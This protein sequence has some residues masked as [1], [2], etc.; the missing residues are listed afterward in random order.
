MIFRLAVRHLICGLSV[1]TI[2]VSLLL[3]ATLLLAGPQTAQAEI[4]TVCP[5][6]AICDY[7]SPEVAVNDPVVVAGDTIDI[8]ASTYVLGTT[9]QVDNSITILGHGSVFDANGIRAI[10]VINAATNLSL[11]NVTIQ[12]GQADAGFGGGALRVSGGATVTVIGGIFEDNQ[13]EFGGAVHNIASTVTIRESVFS[14]NR[15]TAG[16]GG[17]VLTDSGGSTTLIRTEIDGNTA[18]VAGGGLAVGD[19]NSQLNFV[20]STVSNNA[21]LTSVQ[22]VSNL[23]ISGT[24]ISCGESPLGQTFLA[25][26]SA[27]SAFEF[28]IRLNGP[29]GDANVIPSD[30]NIPGGVWLGGSTQTLVFNLDQAVALIPNDTYAIESFIAGAYSIFISPGNDY[31][32]GDRY[33]CDGVFST[34]SDFFFR[35]FGGSPGEGGGIYASTAGIA[36]LFNSTVS[37]NLGDGAVAASGGSVTTLF[38]TIS[39]NSGNGLTAQPNAPGGLVFFTASI[40]AENG[41]NDCAGSNF[42]SSGFNLIGDDNNCVFTPFTGDLIGTGVAPIDP[43]LGPLQDNGGFTATHAIDPNSPALDGAGTDLNLPCTDATDDQRGVVRPGGPACD[44]GAFELVPAA[45]AGPLQT[46]I[47]AAAP[48]AIIIVPDGIYTEQITIGDGKTLR[49]SGPDNVVINA[50]GLGSSAII[51]TGDFTLEGIR[52]TGGSSVDN[53]GNDAVLDGGA[54]Y[55]LN[56]TLAGTNVTF[57]NNSAGGNGGAILNALGVVD[58]QGVVIEGGSATSGGAIHNGSG[59]QLLIGT[60]VACA[61]M[62][63]DVNAPILNMISGNSANTLGG[64]ITGGTI[65]IANTRL[66][67]NSAG[68]GGATDIGAGG[69]LDINCSILDANHALSGSG[70]AVNNSSTFIDE[71]LFESNTAATSGGAF[72]GNSATISNSLFRLNQAGENGGAIATVGPLTSTRN[73]YD[74]NHA[75]Y[76]GAI[77]INGNTFNS[78]NSID[79]LF[80]SNTATHDGGAI[81]EFASNLNVTRGAFQSNTAGDSNGGFAG[82]GGAIYSGRSAVITES[83]FSA[84]RP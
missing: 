49:G 45:A 63:V 62:P 27:L 56:G 16:E 20:A 51:A 25:D 44:I 69:S 64:A 24:T 74:A 81:Y 50:N 78:A 12:N 9:L 77:G 19:N 58:L 71:T 14:G 42:T 3:T 60:A 36:G 66:T 67:G 17:A 75:D 30:L 13:A 5:L 29:V 8:V 55:L 68:Q 52:V 59:S 65:V 21:A 15:A 26:A 72:S 1:S 38:S 32:G 33:N 47:T 84:I 7:Q 39:N 82:D 53:G 22:T 61:G 10:D 57:T 28:N 2:I 4:Y 35:T 41:G 6:P 54:I 34:G 70:G 31:L 40:I 18:S 43:L 11:T 73:E 23:A 46:L 48:G 83:L 76:G 80:T 37:G 79:D